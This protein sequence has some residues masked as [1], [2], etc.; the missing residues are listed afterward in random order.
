MSLSQ[1]HRRQ[2]ISSME[3][4][5]LVNNSFSKRDNQITPVC[6]SIHTQTESR[7]II[8]FDEA[9]QVS[10]NTL[11]R[12][13]SYKNLHS[14]MDKLMRRSISL[15]EIVEEKDRVINEILRKST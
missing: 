1:A 2:P 9:V 14:E 12:T 11:D 15:Q 7:C 3:A 10:T 5:E 6:T 4:F 13:A 8:R